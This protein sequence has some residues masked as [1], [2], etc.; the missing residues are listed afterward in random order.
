MNFRLKAAEPYDNFTYARVTIKSDIYRCVVVPNI[1]GFFR[2]KK[3]KKKISISFANV[4]FSRSSLYSKTN[5][6]T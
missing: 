4:R 3:S 5:Y 1:L 6:L 2:T